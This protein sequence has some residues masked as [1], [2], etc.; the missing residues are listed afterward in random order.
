VIKIELHCGRICLMIGRRVVAVEGDPCRD[1][2]FPGKKW[3]LEMFEE[4]M[5]EVKTDAHD[6]VG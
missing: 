1:P 5:F 4:I 3:K 2:G 6:E